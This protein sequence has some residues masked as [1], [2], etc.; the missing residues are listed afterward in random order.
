MSYYEKYLKYKNKYLQLKAQLGGECDVLEKFNCN[1][2]DECMYNNLGFKCM[3]H[4]CTKNT[5]QETCPKDKCSWNNDKCV[6][7]MKEL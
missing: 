6:K 5:T 4:P 3:D 7:P 1:K 2:K